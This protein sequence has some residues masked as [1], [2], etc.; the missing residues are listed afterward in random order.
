[1]NLPLR[2]LRY[3]FTQV[4]QTEINKPM[5][6]Q[7]SAVNGKTGNW[8]ARIGVGLVSFGVL[9]VVVAFVSARKHAQ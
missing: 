9:W 1:M 3:A 7:L 5:T 4:L 2:G 8:L 6:I